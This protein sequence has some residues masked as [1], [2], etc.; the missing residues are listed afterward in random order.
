M[1][2]LPQYSSSIERT[3]YPRMGERTV[4]LNGARAIITPIIAGDAPLS[5]AYIHK[6]LEI[7]L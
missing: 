2:V 5:S 4:T 3:R 6:I 7:C 1:H